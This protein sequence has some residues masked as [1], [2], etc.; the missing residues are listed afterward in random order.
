[1]KYE[2][3]AG[4]QDFY[5]QQREESTQV[6]QRKQEKQGNERSQSKKPGQKKT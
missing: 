1:M 6:V 5:T 2:S 4:L 3:R